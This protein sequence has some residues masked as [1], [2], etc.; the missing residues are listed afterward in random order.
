MS[1]ITI[2]GTKI[3][4]YITMHDGKY[5]L[6]SEEDGEKKVLM[7]QEEG[8]GLLEFE[9]RVAKR[10]RTEKAPDVIRF[11]KWDCKLKWGEYMNGR[12]ALQLVDAK[13]GELIL[14]ATVNLPKVDLGPDEVF[15]KDYSENEGVLEVLIK[16]GIVKYIGKTKSNFAEISICKVL[17]NADNRKEDDGRQGCTL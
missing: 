9:E 13:N 16:A 1:E 17:I 2:E 12:K 5:C 14:T 3:T 6:I 10:N 8:E 11:K 7:S 15:I 4:K